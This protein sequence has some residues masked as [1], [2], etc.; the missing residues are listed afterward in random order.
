MEMRLVLARVLER[1]QLRAA[2]PKLDA[3]ELRMITLSPK[4]GVRVVLDDPP[5]PA[6]FGAGR[7][8][9][10]RSAAVA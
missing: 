1:T 2:V 9:A 5:S 8:A 6:G 7:D 10:E 4:N 3:A